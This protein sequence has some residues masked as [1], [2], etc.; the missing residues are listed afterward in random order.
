MSAKEAAPAVE[1][2]G[3]KQMEIEVAHIMLDRDATTTIPV[4]CFVYEVEIYRE[5]HGEMSVREIS[6]EVVTVEAFSAADAY[7][8]L[9]RK[10]KQNISAV[11]LIYRTPQVLAKASGLKYQ[12]G[13]DEA[14]R[15]Q[16]SEVV[17]NSKPTP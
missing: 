11:R 1:E 13:D 8:S 17:D 3:V 4:T 10:F 9:L 6:T 15:F 16:Q 2:D 5:I 12:K 7:A 14:V